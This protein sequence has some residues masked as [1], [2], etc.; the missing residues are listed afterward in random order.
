[1]GDP[2]G[3][4][5]SA[6]TKLGSVVAANYARGRDERR[7]VYRRFQEAVVTYAMQIRDSRCSPEALGLAQHGHG[8]VGE[9]LHRCGE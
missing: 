3:V 4:A 6:A 1:M 5:A 7:Q 2:L 8:K 9:C